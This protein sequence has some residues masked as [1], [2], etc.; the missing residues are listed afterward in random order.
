MAGLRLTVENRVRVSF[1]GRLLAALAAY[2]LFAGIAGG[3]LA[4]CGTEIAPGALAVGC[5]AAAAVIAAGCVL[6]GRAGSSGKNPEGESPSSAPLATGKAERIFYLAAAGIVVAACLILLGSFSGGAAQLANDLIVRI[7]ERTQDY[8]LPFEAG[9]EGD[10]MFFC[11]VASAALALAASLMAQH[12]GVAPC[13]VLGA[14]VLAGIVS[15]W[16]PVGWWT[17]ILALGTCLLIGSRA[18]LSG[19]AAPSPALAWTLACV[20]AVCAVSAVGTAA[21]VRSGTADVRGVQSAVDELLWNMRY[22]DAEFAMPEGDLRDIGD[23]RATDQVALKV[24]TDQPT[25]EYLRGFVG[26]RYSDSTWQP[27]ESSAVM[28][29]R[30]TLYWLSQ[31][32]FAADAQLSQVAQLTGYDDVNDA[33]LSIEQVN[34]RGPYAYLPYGYTT[35]SSA[36][37]ITDLAQTRTQAEGAERIAYGADITRKAYLLQEA[38]E[39]EQADAGSTANAASGVGTADTAPSGLRTYLDDESAY[40]AFAEEA[41]LDIP[42]DVRAVLERL[43]GEPAQLT[44]EQA[45]VQVLYYLDDTVAYADGSEKKAKS[46]STPDAG[47][48]AAA[49]DAENDAESAAE[50]EDFVVEFLTG[51]RSG[52]SVHYATAATLMLRY[53]GVPARY[54]EGYVLN[55][56]QLDEEG[57]QVGPGGEYTLTEK[58]AHAW[59][60]YYLDGV[61]WLPYDVTPGWRAAGYYETTPNTELIVES[62]N[63]SVGE[64]DADAVWNPPEQEPEEEEEAESTPSPIFAELDFLLLEW[65]WALLGFLLTLLIAFIVRDALLHARLSRFLEEMQDG[66]TPTDKAVP[67]LFSYAVLLARSCGEVALG[68]APF[69]AQADAVCAAGLCEERTFA[70]AAAANDRALFGVADTSQ[71]DVRAVAACVDELRAGLHATTSLPARFWQRHVRCLW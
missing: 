42:D 70:A 18:V 16:V 66:R 67:A 38:L 68:N 34:V 22:G 64:A 56:A 26:E 30:D 12:G 47:E 51:T 33:A 2:A 19:D 46:G 3:V 39:A 23:L 25:F 10:L 9:S 11:G 61:G 20:L 71:D 43:Y 60:E 40:R 14:A 45:K 28:G 8:A 4:V 13:I 50:D 65:P 24:S 1:V 36:R 17:A 62:Q 32:G 48:E 31:D 15:G 63:W 55:T 58:Q 21:A 27:L 5:I 53:F 49:A 37:L 29:N 54:V 44:T 69:E 41:Y 52:Y 35:G 7:G 59:V 57:E 6:A